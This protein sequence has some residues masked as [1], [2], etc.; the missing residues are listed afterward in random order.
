M[1][2]NLLTYIL[3]LIWIPLCNGQTASGDTEP[4]VVKHS[5]SYSKSQQVS[6]QLVVVSRPQFAEMLQ[7]YIAW[8][9][10]AGY[11][12]HEFYADSNDR[13]QIK[14]HLQALYDSATTLN[15]H[16]RYILIVGDVEHI[17]SFIGRHKPSDEFVT[18]ITDM[19]YGEY[20][21]D[22]I[23]EAMVGRWS[24]GDSS[25]LRMVMTKS[26]A[27]EQ[28]MESR[29]EYL[30]E[31]L[32]VAGREYGSP[33]PTTTNGHVNYEK[34]RLAEH[35]ATIDTHCFFNPSS[36]QYADSIARLMGDGM[37][38][39]NYTG[40]CNIGGW[41]NPN[42]NN[43]TIDTTEGSGNY[44]IYINNC[45]S[46]NS[47]GG[48]C[49]GERL[50]RKADG[51]AVA[52]I[53]ATNETLWNEDYIWSVGAK[54][55]ATTL[56]TYDPTKM[57]FIDRL[58]HT[59]GEGEREQAHTMG[60]LLW[61][62]NYAV[63]QSG[64]R[65]DA[66]YWEIYSI[67]G[68]PTLMP[69]IGKPDSIEMRTSD[70]LEMGVSQIQVWTSVSGA[71]VTATTDS[72]LL[73][74]VR[75]DSTGAGI[76]T[77]THGTDAG[78]I[79]ITATAQFHTPI[80]QTVVMTR[81]SGGRNTLTSHQYTER[82]DSIHLDVTIKNIGQQPAE[83]HQIAFR[84]NGWSHTATLPTLSA[85]E[86]TTVGIDIAYPIGSNIITPTV[87][88][89][90]GGAAYFTS[91][92]PYETTTVNPYLESITFT[93][94]GNGTCEI[95]ATV[96]NTL[97]DTLTALLNGETY[98]IGALEQYVMVQ[99]V[100]IEDTAHHIQAVYILACGGWQHTDSLWFII[101]NGHES[102]E[103][104]DFDCFPWQTTATHP[105][106]I[107]SG[108]HQQGQYSA[109]SQSIGHNQRSDLCININVS[110]E[111]SIVF[112]S[113][114]SSEDRYDRLIFYIDDSA[115]MTL[116]G[117]R[118][119][120][121][122]AYVLSAGRHHLLWRYEKDDSQSEGEDGA[123]IDNI[124]FPP[125]VW[126]SRY[127]YFDSIPDDVSIRPATEDTAR[128]ALSVYPNPATSS[129]TIKATGIV[130]GSKCHITIYDPLGKTVATWTSQEE[131]ANGIQYSTTDLRLG[132]YFV[133]LSTSQQ[134]ITERLTITP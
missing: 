67:L 8:K 116:S 12:V 75:T 101:G 35:D 84:W 18:H 80:S 21:G 16:P 3:L 9:Q 130:P 89:S 123:W 7:P 31:A 53:G 72:T 128:I 50:L 113:R 1:R 60:E 68:D 85:S 15:P 134:R 64:S 69:Y 98:R 17:Q 43:I 41:I 115:A 30:K 29:Q 54:L 33:A 2:R 81:P 127:G 6:E 109:K 103:S 20:T 51:G 86:S 79:V 62:G 22:Y 118:P 83:G 88:L 27:Y 49:F 122:H 92:L 4:A 82:N 58:L 91:T 34:E 120:E 119:W 105:W 100:P 13:D 77:L 32:L 76:I 114:V 111:D 74:T 44:G 102:Y 108:I 52:V 104:G 129:V 126:E 24:I 107:D 57:G 61:A 46:S 65:Y 90:E 117:E 97:N 106:Q 93:P 96:R 28:G 73:G 121:R 133:E 66:Y 87:E 5:Q 110:K 71:M 47:F 11:Q 42:I 10:Q 94:M 40:H 59:R 125:C 38:Y 56:P 48:S 70:T 131:I 26:M 124:H 19:Y 45:C 78:Q 39:V 112:W 63:T 14:A 132:V 25:D 37:G 99:T 23:P 95:S 55:P 36:K